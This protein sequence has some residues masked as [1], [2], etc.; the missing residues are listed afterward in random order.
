M[1]AHYLRMG[2]GVVNL[3]LFTWCEN[4]E[5]E[6]FRDLRCSES[7]TGIVEIGTGNSEPTFNVMSTWR[8]NA[9]F[10]MFRD[11]RCSESTTGVVEIGTGNSEPTFNVM[12]TWRENTDFKMF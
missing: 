4:T 3:P 11:L 6:M 2:Q 5:F 1:P 9:D 10:E 7:T 12:F 8:E